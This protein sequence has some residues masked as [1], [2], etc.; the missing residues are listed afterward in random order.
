MEKWHT[1]T[2][3]ETLASFDVDA[4]EG[5]DAAE[6][7]RRLETYGANSLDAKKGK[8]LLVRLLEQF[9]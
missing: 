8:S 6:A 4:A 7:A 3:A 2:A 5:L 1:K 9:H